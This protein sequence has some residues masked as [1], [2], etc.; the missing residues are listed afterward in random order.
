MKLIGIM[1][2]E[3]L[4][5]KLACALTALATAIAVGSC[6]GAVVLLDSHDR[7]TAKLLARKEAEMK[8]RM[9]SLNDEMRKAA[10][11]LGFNLLILP[12][13]QNLR[14]WH[15]EDYAA[16]DMPEEYVST[17]A[18][19]GIV[20]VRHF[21]PSLQKRLV[22]PEI[23]RTIIL[24]GTRGEV[25]N[26]HK[27]P[28]QPLVQPVPTGTIVLGYELHRS[29]G[30]AVGDTVRLM[31]R[32]FTVHLCH[33]ERGSKDDISAWISLREAQELLGKPGRV[34]TILALKCLCMGS[35][36]IALL[37]Q[38]IVR[39][40]PGTQ[41]IEVGSRVVA[42]A[43]ARLKLK[44]QSK[45][46]IEAERENRAQLR[47]QRELLVS[48][49]VPSIVVACAVWIAHMGFADV[50]ERDAEIAILKAI[51]YRSGQVLLLFLSKSI[52]VGLVGGTAGLLAATC[53]GYWYGNR[54]VG[55]TAGGGA[56]L[57]TTQPG[58]CATAL[59]VACLLAV[60]AGW[61]PAFVATQRDPADALRNE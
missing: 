39:I 34:N 44:K 15:T 22:W 17:L 42:R 32:D 37:R 10:L 45:Q 13:D 46:M 56:G 40:L 19:S 20:T 24:V 57:L 6:V 14:D 35:Q 36:D 9:A 2:K 33:N 61:L 27:D 43:E 38:E 49:L 50:K 47:V 52:A 55:E 4:Y 58:L 60:I 28:R 5:R 41:A 7:Q 8:A 59:S 25:P 48:I 12:S 23:K 11:K 21:L 30:L 26:M 1:M 51:G 53:A 18:A 29:L 31:G 3:I 16:K 54:T